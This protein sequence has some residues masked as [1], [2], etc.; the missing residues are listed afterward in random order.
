MNIDVLKASKAL[1]SQS[2]LMDAEA[3]KVPLAVL[4]D[5]DPRIATVNI[6]LSKT[7][8]RSGRRYRKEGFV[9]CP[10]R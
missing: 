8:N 7:F 10:C 1:F 5:F 4:S 3:A 6:D 9:R 2:G